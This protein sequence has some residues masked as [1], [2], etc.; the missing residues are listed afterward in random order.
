MNNFKYEWLLKNN[1]HVS[2]IKKNKLKVFSCFTGGGGSTMGYKLAGFNHLGG[3][4]IDKKIA[5]LYILNHN[6][7]YFYIE[8]IR[9]FNNRNDLPKE[10]YNLDILDGSPPC[11]SFSMAGTREKNWNKKK[12]FREGQIKQ[13]L[14]E[15]VFIYCDTILKLLP[16]IFILENVKGIII[17]NAKIY[18]KEI[19]SILKIKYNIQTFLLNGSTM[20]LPQK[21]ERV[22]FIGTRKDLKLSK[23]IF[24]FNEKPIIFSK[25][26]DENNTEFLNKNTKIYQYWLKRKKTDKTF[27]DICLRLENKPNN[28]GRHL[29]HDNQVLSTIIVQDIYIYHSEYKRLSK[30]E[31]CLASSFPLDYNFDKIAVKQIIGLSVPP[32]MVGN[33]S[34]QIYL[35][36]FK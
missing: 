15:I 35:Q 1:Y 30:K 21:R 4:E 18:A 23:L 10:L 14:D 29:I 11:S 17:G 13:V 32:L 9:I 22:F 26:K 31:L 20:G 6:P 25:I 12:K 7:K 28:F 2:G 34:Y 5:N 24:N 8:D 33:I 16:K 36:L 19:L 27:N 3:I